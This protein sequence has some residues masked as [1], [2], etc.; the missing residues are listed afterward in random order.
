LHR[1]VLSCA[2]YLIDN[3]TN[4]KNDV[5]VRQYFDSY[6]KILNEE[7]IISLSKIYSE[8]DTPHPFRKNVTAKEM[9]EKDERKIKDAEEQGFEV[10]VVWDSEYRK[11][12]ND[13][14]NKC[15]E[16]LNK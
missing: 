15:L 3:G 16:F 10:F 2:Y 5:E 7:N 1:F 4:L 14:L 13:V 8:S 6:E 9:W 12:P 11:N